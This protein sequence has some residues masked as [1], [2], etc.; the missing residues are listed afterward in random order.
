MFIICD[1]T[2][3]RTEIYTIACTRHI[4]IATHFTKT[5]RQVLHMLNAILKIYC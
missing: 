4:S 3:Q 2:I 1:V 5:F